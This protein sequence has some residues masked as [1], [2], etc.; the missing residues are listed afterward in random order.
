MAAIRPLPKQL[1]FTLKPYA[2]SVSI[3]L[4]STNLSFANSEQ[5]Y[6]ETWDWQAGTCCK[7]SSF[8]NGSY[9]EPKR[10]WEAA[11]Q[12]P[13]QSNINI[14]ADSSTM[15]EDK[16]ELFG[17]LLITQGY[18]KILANGAE[19]DRKNHQLTVENGFTLREPELK[20]SGEQAKFNTETGE[21][22]L[23]NTK[24]LNHKTGMR[25]SA[26]SATRSADGSL[27]L[28]KTRYTQCPP[29]QQTWSLYS[30]NMKID[31]N[32]GK[33]IAR[34]TK[35]YIGKVPV[36]YSPFLTFPTD[37]RRKTGFLWP[38][39]ASSNS[40][41]QIS[42]PFYWNIAPNYDATFTPVYISDR[43]TMGELE[44]RY[45][46]QFS[47]WRLSGA[48]LGNDKLS[49]SD[50]WLLSLQQSSAISSVWD[51]GIDFNRV[52]DNNYFKDLNIS[53]LEVKRKTHLN[54]H[55]WF[56]Y[57][58]SFWD[59]RILFAD[60]QTINDN[61]TKPYKRLPQ[62]T[63]V[64][65]RGSGSFIA[66]RQIEL[67]YTHFD[68]DDA[69][70]K[71]G[72]FVTGDRFYAR[73]SLSYP[74]RWAAGF[75][76]PKLQIQ[77]NAYQ[78]DILNNST[79]SDT[80]S[81][82][83]SSV[84]LDSGLFFERDLNF[85]EQDWTQTLEPRFYTRFSEYKD[86]SDQPLFDTGQYGFS[87]SRLFSDNRF[88][89]K[90][91]IDDAEQITLGLTQRLINNS[92]AKE[93]LRLSLGQIFYLDDRKVQLRGN[94]IPDGDKIS[95][96]QIAG[97]LNIQVHD[98]LWFNANSLWDSRQ[99]YVDEGG[100]SFYWENNNQALVN[101]GYRYRRNGVNISGFGRRDLE[102]FDTSFVYP[103]S[104]HWRTMGRYQWDINQKRSLEETVGIEYHDC[105]WMIQLA[106]QKAAAN[107]IAD[108]M[109]GSRLDY[110]HTFVLQFQLKGLGSTGTQATDLFR[111]SIL[112]YR[113]R[114]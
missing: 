41:L 113:E 94:N 40:S 92:S 105:C 61:I 7:P 43:G 31:Q 44:L 60:Y 53:S 85:S 25:V 77:H 36:L 59:S 99:D 9:I 12:N 81:T 104:R 108:N 51:F 32:E 84:S 50:R 110:E 14:N 21:G 65:K 52:S 24:I 26:Q 56:D 106:Y 8:C 2:L 33:G 103:I 37:N 69:V 29:G 80:P 22:V 112:G 47:R 1:C 46:N 34:N 42:T 39:F 91:R 55:A 83:A 76:T 71:G 63:N 16:I 86:Q 78:L 13:Q 38:S 97:E 28:R 70:Q 66:D 54:Q 87:Y 68:H 4:L 48:Y 35:L 75:I 57:R 19:L 64:F 111:E 20:I 58:S 67:Q 96:S 100:A 17:D 3:A 79:A 88:S 62:W 89:G 27:K 101:L 45:I 72:K 15:T 11:E 95:N 10:D 18:R 109:G 82:T 74:M 93:L 102:Q 6:N 90:D 5:N 107:E 23:K 98:K 114:D 49:D 30:G 73:G